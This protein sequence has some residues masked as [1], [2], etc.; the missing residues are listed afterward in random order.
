MYTGFNSIPLNIFQAIALLLVGFLN[1]ELFTFRLYLLGPIAGIFIVASIFIILLG[2]FDP[3]M[4]KKGTEIIESI[5]KES[6]GDQIQSE[7]G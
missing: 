5:T 4:K 7:G 6:V 1:N 3:F 2:N